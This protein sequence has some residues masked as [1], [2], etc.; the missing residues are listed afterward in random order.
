M[1]IASSYDDSPVGAPRQVEDSAGARRQERKKSR[2]RTNRLLKAEILLHGQQFAEPSS[3][4][5][6]ICDRRRAR[7]IGRSSTP[8]APD[9][10]I[11]AHSHLL[12]AHEPNP[13]GDLKCRSKPM[14]QM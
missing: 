1:D 3:D 2:N 9:R 5:S 12:I 4:D 10:S 14:F 11:A 6:S 13:I 7:T 8:F